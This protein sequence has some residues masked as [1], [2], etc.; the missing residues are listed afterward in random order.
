MKPV[1]RR[2]LLLYRLP[3]EPSAPRVA[4]WRALKR[5]DGAY[6]QDGAYII[7]HNEL[8]A[9]TL[10]TIAHDIRN[11]GGEAT[12]INASKVDDEKHLQERL[13][14]AMQAPAPRAATKKA[15]KMPR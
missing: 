2:I 13:R 11:F 4:I 8:N 12:L 7:R 6:L 1:A 5:L 15:R 9:V 3:S 10:D 14:A